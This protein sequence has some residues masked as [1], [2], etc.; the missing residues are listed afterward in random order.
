MF[1]PDAEGP[2]IVKVGWE[3]SGYVLGAQSR[4]YEF[5]VEPLTLIEQLIESG[6]IY[7]LLGGVAIIVLAAVIMFKRRK[8]GRKS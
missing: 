4:E 5:T 7:A 2:W 6:A 1:M 3:G 8:R